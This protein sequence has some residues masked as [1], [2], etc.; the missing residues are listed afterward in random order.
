MST[1]E[2]AK[3]NGADITD[4]GIVPFSWSGRTAMMNAGKV[5]TNYPDMNVNVATLDVS[6]MDGFLQY[7]NNYGEG[8]AYSSEVAALME[9]QENL[10]VTLLIPDGKTW[11]DVQY[12]YDKES[13]EVTQ[14]QDKGFDAVMVLSSNNNHAAIR[15]IAI[16][17]G[18]VFDFAAGKISLEE[19]LASAD[20]FYVTDDSVLD[21]RTGKM[22]SYRKS[23]INSMSD[24]LSLTEIND[25]IKL[26]GDIVGSNYQLAETYMNTLRSQIKGNN[27]FGRKVQN[28]KDTSGIP[29]CIAGYINAYYDVIAAL[30]K[31]IE[32][33]TKQVLC[34]AQKYVDLDN[35]MTR[36]SYDFLFNPVEETQQ[37]APTEQVEDTPKPPASQQTTQ[38]VNLPYVNPRPSYGSYPSGGSGNTTQEE[39]TVLKEF[40]NDDN[41]KIIFKGTGNKV[42]DISYEISLSID[43][44]QDEIVKQLEEKYKD[45]AYFDRIEVE[46]NTIKVIFRPEY[47]AG[48]GYDEIKNMILNGEVKNGNVI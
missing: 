46:N 31:K 12:A 19:F 44:N 6:L 41:S 5:L 28:F 40:Q 2:Y 29:G 4:V 3:S 14:L 35:G 23:A 38:P 1:I 33:E 21:K 15:E 48:M 8:G 7:A 47:F 36:D 37:E 32:E 22:V 18:N 26:D 11:G 13:R 43:S 34:V 42:T 17:G 25:E 30:M 20:A 24:F 27:Y 10:D 9:H 45:L 16:K 39:I